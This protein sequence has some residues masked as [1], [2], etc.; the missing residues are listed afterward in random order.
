[1][2]AGAK[3]ILKAAFP[4]IP[5]Q[6]HAKEVG[7]K[8][9]EVWY[10]ETLTPILVTDEFTIKSNG[11][12]ELK[13]GDWKACVAAIPASFLRKAYRDN[14]VRLFSANVRDYLGARRSDSN[15]NNGIMQTARSEPDNFWAYNNGITV[16]GERLF[17]DA[18]HLNGSRIF[19]CQRCSDNGS[20]RIG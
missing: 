11:A 2:E 6:V 17:V 13:M 9:L 1:V 18:G 7:T 20:S 4:R 8:T 16:F 5:V 19:C 14:G 12:F 3:A 15:I 10:T